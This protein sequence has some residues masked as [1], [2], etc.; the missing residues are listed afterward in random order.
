MKYYLIISGNLLLNI[1]NTLPP[2]M[3]LDSGL[4]IEEVTSLPPRFADWSN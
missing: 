2:Q 3:V 1:Y 4:T